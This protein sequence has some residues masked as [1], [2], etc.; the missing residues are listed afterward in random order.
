MFLL[1]YLNYAFLKSH[2][3]SSTLFNMPYGEKVDDLLF[4]IRCII[5]G[6]SSV[7]FVFDLFVKSLDNLLTDRR[8]VLALHE[9]LSNWRLTCSRGSGTHVTQI[10]S[11]SRG[12]Q[13]GVSNKDKRKI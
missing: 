7:E 2:L 5:D 12:R 10:E 8:I 9:A 4:D 3:D 13:R 1:N 11:W 6:F